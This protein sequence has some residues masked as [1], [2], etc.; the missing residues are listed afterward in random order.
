MRS[1]RLFAAAAIRIC[2]PMYCLPHPS[3]RRPFV[4]ALLAALALMAHAP[5]LAQS[6]PAAAP[7]SIGTFEDWQAATH[8]EGGQTV[9]Y[10]LTRAKASTPALPGRGDVVLTVTHRPTLRDAVALSAGFAYPARA[11][12]T[13]EAGP[14]SLDFYTDKRAAFARNGAGAVGAFI[15]AS[16]AVAKSPMP[17]PPGA[18]AP[19]AKA[20]VADTFSLKGFSAAYAAINKAC[21]PK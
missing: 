5:A 16:Q 17:K 21:P 13:V 12:V 14:V 19:G 10:A 4:P 1:G 7:K 9:C 2:A 11:A 6:R 15:R 3:V 18:K 20:P 8:V